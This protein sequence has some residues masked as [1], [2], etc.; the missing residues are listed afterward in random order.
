[1]SDSV[2]VEIELRDDVH[3]AAVMT[4]PR[5]EKVVA[6]Y[7]A[8]YGITCYLPLRRRADRYQRR[9]VVT[10]LPIFLSCLFV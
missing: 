6:R 3:W 9:T 7:C 1:V 8:S 2:S 5:Y 4:K 10:W